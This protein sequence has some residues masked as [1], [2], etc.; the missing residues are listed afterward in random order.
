[1][2]KLFTVL[3]VLVLVVVLTTGCQSAKQSSEP[4]PSESSS[5]ATKPEES[6]GAEKDGEGYVIA[7]SP[8]F[9]GNSYQTQNWELFQE[10]AKQ[11]SEIKEVTLANPDFNAETQ[12]NLIQNLIDQGVDA[13]VMQ[14]VS[15]TA[16]VDVVEQANEAG[17]KVILQDSM[18]NTDVVT[19]K[20]RVDEKEWGRITA[21]WLIEQMGGKGKIIALNGI[22]G[23]TSNQDRWDGAKEVFDANPNIEILADAN[24]DWEQ[25]KAQSTV[26]GWLAAYPEINGVWSQGGEMTVGAI[27]EFKKAG[28]DLVPMCGEAYNGFLKTWQ[29]MQAQ[30]FSSIAPSLPCYNVQV[31]L[32]L[33]VRALKGEDVPAEVVLPLPVITDDN[34]EKYVMDDQPDDYWVF[35]KL[36]QNEVGQFIADN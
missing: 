27:Q 30:G 22:A 18:A 16:L 13:I 33:A 32:E 11:Y 15:P 3:L 35:D 25:A 10:T 8:L 21:E 36:T 19:S 1:M 26:S 7:W 20:V 14:A 9:L 17:I 29:D 24:C 28:R 6:S 12:I 34:L 2:K 5:A 4:L 31:S 23:N